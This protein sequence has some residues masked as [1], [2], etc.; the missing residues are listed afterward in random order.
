MNK[1]KFGGKVPFG[2]DKLP[3]DYIQKFVSRD[4]YPDVPWAES[5]A[6]EG[7]KVIGILSAICFIGAIAIMW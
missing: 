4:P 5:Y 7:G 6:P 3:A 2:M 1:T